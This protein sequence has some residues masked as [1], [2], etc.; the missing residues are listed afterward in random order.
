MKIAQK[1][2]K[3]QVTRGPLI[4]LVCIQLLM[5]IEL[6]HHRVLAQL[7]HGEEINGSRVWVGKKR[8]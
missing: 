3:A 2:E 4:G 6:S 5:Q 1:T 8:E 7:E